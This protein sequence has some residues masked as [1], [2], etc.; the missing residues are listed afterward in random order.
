MKKLITITLSLLLL[1]SF[2]TMAFAEEAQETQETPYG[3]VLVNM[4]GQSYAKFLKSYNF[5]YSILTKYTTDGLFDEYKDKIITDEESGMTMTIFSGYTVWIQ[6]KDGTVLSQ[7]GG[8]YV[9]SESE[10]MF[11]VNDQFVP[12]ELIIYFDRFI[13]Q[14]Q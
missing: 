11:K 3:Y 12:L 6:D 4:D 13:H 7:F 2:S 5:T 10:F 9:Y 14:R 8:E 1:L